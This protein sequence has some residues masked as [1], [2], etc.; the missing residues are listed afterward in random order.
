MTNACCTPTTCDALKAQGFAAR[1]A[2]AAATLNCP[3]NCNSGE[4]CNPGT[5]ACCKALTCADYPGQCGVKSNGCGGVIN[6]NGN[7]SGA[8][9]A[10]PAATSAARPSRART[11]GRTRAVPSATR[12]AGRSTAAARTRTRRAGLQPGGG[13]TCCKAKTCADFAGQCGT[14][15]DGCGGVLSAVARVRST[16][17]QG[18]QCGCTPLTPNPATCGGQCGPVPNGCGGT[19]SVPC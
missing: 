14:I 4:T 7:C 12:A 15:S 11:S 5:N 8:R 10:T 13:S 9:R 2:T 16:R 3:G 17:T 19:M 6:C 18:R 1:S